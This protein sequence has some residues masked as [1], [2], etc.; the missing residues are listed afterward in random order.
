[1]FKCSAQPSIA[2]IVTNSTLNSPVP[3]VRRVLCCGSRRGLRLTLAGGLVA[4]L[5]SAER[6]FAS[7]SLED[8]GAIRVPMVVGASKFEQKITEAPSAVTIVTR[9]DI[10]Q[11]GY[12]TL[13]DL[14]RAVR[15]FYVTNNRAYNFT[16]LRGLNRPGDFGGRTL[17]NVDGHRLN[18]PIYDSA[19]TDTDLLVDLDLVERVEVIRGPGSSLYGN[20]AFAAVI[21]IVTRRGREFRGLEASGLAGSLDTSSARV[22]F[23]KK[24]SAGVE[25]LVSGSYLDSGGHARLGYPEFGRENNGIAENVD[26]TVAR[27]AFSSLRFG[28][29]T[30]CGG[31]IDRRKQAPTAQYGT[32]FN[33]PRLVFVDVRGYAE[34][35]YERAFADGW[36][37]QTRAYLDS[38]RYQAALPFDYPPVTINRDYSDAR[39]AGA[40]AL[41]SRTLWRRHRVTVGGEFRRD[42]QLR[43]QNVDVAPSNTYV[44]AQ[45]RAASHAFYLQDESKLG[46][47]LTVNVGIR[48]D[49]FS[50]FGDTVNPRGALIWQPA[51]DSALKFL[52]GEA[53]RAPNVY[54]LDY[55]GPTYKAN[56]ALA[57]E[58]IRSQEFV[59]EQGL[60][61]GLRANASVFF[62]RIRGLIG[63]ELDPADGMNRFKNLDAVEAR[64]FELELEGRWAQGL[65]GRV[66]YTRAVA[67]D[68]ATNRILDNS[69]RHLGKASVAVPCAGGRF[70]AAFELQAMSRRTTVQGGTVGAF[71]V[72]HA[73]LFSRRL[74]PGLEIAVS[75]HNLF[76]RRYR[77]PVSSDFVQDA[78][79]QDGRTLQVKLT[80]RPGR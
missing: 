79:P 46:S 12:R 41:V 40:E 28:D 64:G 70:F 66:S 21:N 29:F 71:W 13:G 3:F 34:L 30:L 6:D 16:G 80:W 15:G 49:R 17:I 18:E 42:F 20:N 7:L 37:A 38:Y 61:G 59:I 24:F 33:D 32:V 9:E 72:A 35:K 4:S 39:W 44:D 74:A 58:T 36:F 56:P 31:Y 23:G 14:L 26:G 43:V 2:W 62:N 54:E 63:Q 78:L 73:T 10:Q 27:S 65:R 69:P 53:F 1:M 77:D 25:L 57:P 11:F 48:Y 52:H 45:R 22:S 75:A 50:T 51:P 19:F 67:R 60:P 76:N 68:T 55:I 8:L 47:Q 5:F